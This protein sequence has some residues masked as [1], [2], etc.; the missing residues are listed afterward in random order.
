MAKKKKTNKSI[1]TNL[2]TKTVAQRK[3]IKYATIRNVTGNSKLAQEAKGWSEK[4]IFEELDIVIPARKPK[5]KPL[6]KEKKERLRNLQSAKFNYAVKKGI[7]GEQANFLRNKT[8]KQIDKD[9]SY[10]KEYTTKPIKLKSAKYYDRYETWKE[11]SRDDQL[12]PE[13]VRQARLINLKKGLD[14]NERY[15][16]AV[17]FYQYTRGRTLEHWSKELDYDKMNEIVI[18]RGVEKR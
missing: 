9:V 1:R 6:P 10:Q 8:Y 15:G 11:L 13:V 4:R 7:S 3:K 12:P 17:V 14:I 5:L 2:K 18:Y 16:F